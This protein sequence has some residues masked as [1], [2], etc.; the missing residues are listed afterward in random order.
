[1]ICEVCDVWYDPTSG[2]DH[3]IIQN[4][5]WLDPKK[6]LLHLD[7]DL[8]DYLQEMSFDLDKEMHGART[9]EF[10]ELVLEW[11]KEVQK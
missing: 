1:M 10:W 11:Q 9:A 7:N 4:I 5:M 8:G 6:K 3:R 2:C